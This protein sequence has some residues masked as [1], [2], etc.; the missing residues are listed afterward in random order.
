MR[1]VGGWA[2]VVAGAALAVPQVFMTA[3]VPLVF[4][5][6]VALAFFGGIAVADAGV[7][8]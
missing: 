4:I 2:L 6:G 1:S 5:V 8:R 7:A 3:P